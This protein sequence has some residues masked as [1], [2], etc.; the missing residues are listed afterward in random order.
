MECH[1][2]SEIDMA[3]SKICWCQVVFDKGK[4]FP[5]IR[6][7][8]KIYKKRVYKKWCP[9]VVQWDTTN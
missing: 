7:D 1:S 6:I 9:T 2:G 4:R 8:N 5:E 3:H